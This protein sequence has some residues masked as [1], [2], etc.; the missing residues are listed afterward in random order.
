M[1]RWEDRKMK[2]LQNT[3][4]KLQ[5]NSKLQCPKL[6]TITVY[7]LSSVIIWSV[8]CHLYSHLLNFL[9]SQLPSFLLYPLAA[10]GK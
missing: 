3:K 2:K 9:S 10:G 8:V 7:S 1:G 6:Q 5:T 4:Y